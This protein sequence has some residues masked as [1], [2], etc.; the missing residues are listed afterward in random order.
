M[1][2]APGGLVRRQRRSP[3]PRRSALMGLL[4]KGGLGSGFDRLRGGAF[5]SAMKQRIARYFASGILALALLGAAWAGPLEDGQAA[6]HR[7]DFAAALRHFR[8]SAEEGNASAQHWLGFMYYYGAGVP[9]NYTIAADW[10]LKAAEQ[11][12]FLA[13][14]DLGLMY[15][16]GKGVTQDYGE[17]L[18]W[19][20][21]AADQ[22]Y[23]VAQYNL[24]L[25][26]ANALGVPQN[27]IQAHMWLNLAVAN[28]TEQ[29]L[30]DEA[31]NNLDILVARMTPEQIAEAQRLAAEWKPK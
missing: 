13:Q 21:P 25:A 1:I 22:G 18:K 5:I 12:D 29:V 8:T 4:A 14:T 30:R 23:A 6:L 7:K 2:A 31:K 28:T 10:Y 3:Q 20:R 27:Y 19:L 24:G 11:G 9:Q 26:Y 15:G 17:A 16:A